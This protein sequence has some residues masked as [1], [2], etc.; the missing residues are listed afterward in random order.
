VTGTEIWCT[1]AWQPAG[2]AGGEGC[3]CTS[4]NSSRASAFLRRI[5]ALV[6]FEA[7][8]SPPISISTCS[9]IL[10]QEERYSMAGKCPC[11]LHQQSPGRFHTTL[12]RRLH[13]SLRCSVRATEPSPPR[14]SGPAARTRLHLWVRANRPCLMCHQI[15]L[16]HRAVR[17]AHLNGQIFAFFTSHTP[18]FV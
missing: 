4:S 9:C 7:G 18:P 12:L 14:Y 6:S 11:D 1:R 5:I 10:S 8:N 16:L 17:T 3:G 2:M 15:S 13:L